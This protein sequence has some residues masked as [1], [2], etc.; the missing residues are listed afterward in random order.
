[1]RFSLREIELLDD[2]LTAYL[3]SFEGR[4]VRPDEAELQRLRLRIEQTRWSTEPVPRRQGG[5]V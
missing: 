5:T 2:A 1:M 4:I 3:D